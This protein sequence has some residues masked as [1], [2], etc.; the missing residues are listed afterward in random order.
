MTVKRLR[1]EKLTTNTL[2]C[3]KWFYEPVKMRGF[4]QADHQ[5]NYSNA[6]CLISAMC[7][8][9]HKTRVKLWPNHTESGQRAMLHNPG[10]R[11]RG[12]APVWP[13][14]APDWS[15]QA[16]PLAKMFDKQQELRS[17][18]SVVFEKL[19][20]RSAKL[21]EARQRFTPASTV[22]LPSVHAGGRVHVIL[23]IP[24]LYHIVISFEM[25]SGFTKAFL[26][27]VWGEAG[28]SIAGAAFVHEARRL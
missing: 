19:T 3:W 16:L 24:L 10:G 26:I 8:Y 21:P 11:Y 7:R 23:S 13:L 2:T 5:A 27:S 17:G 28:K 1:G 4:I 9:H 6:Q 25:F 22:S 18:A 20:F 15:A 14:T 12:S